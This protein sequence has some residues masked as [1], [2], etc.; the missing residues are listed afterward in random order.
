MRIRCP[1]FIRKFAAKKISKLLLEETGIDVDIF[2]YDVSVD[3]KGS[4][5][6][7]YAGGWVDVDKKELKRF[8]EEL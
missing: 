6:R 4:K 7:F 3:T 1:R 8:I 5:Y 2:L